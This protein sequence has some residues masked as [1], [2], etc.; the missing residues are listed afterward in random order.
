MGVPVYPVR[1]E[2]IGNNLIILSRPDITWKYV[3]FGDSTLD[4]NVNFVP[5][6]GQYDVIIRSMIKL[7]FVPKK[8]IVLNPKNPLHTKPSIF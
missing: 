1:E 6:K 5:L 2:F 4:I 7:E 8:I 3:W